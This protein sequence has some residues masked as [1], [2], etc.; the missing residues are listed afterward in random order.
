MVGDRHRAVADARGEHLGQ[1]RRNR[2]VGQRRQHAQ[3]Q[4]QRNDADDARQ[5]RDLPFERIA[6]A[7]EPALDD[8]AAG[9]GR[10]PFVAVALCADGQ[11]RLRL[12]G[13]RIGYAQ[14]GQVLQ[15]AAAGAGLHFGEGI[16]F[17]GRAADRDG[18]RARAVL[19]ARVGERADPPEHGEEQRQRGQRADDDRF[20]APDAVGPFADDDIEAHRQRTRDQQHPFDHVLVDPHRAAQE[21]QAGEESGV[22]DR[23]EHPGDAEQR[24]ED[25]LGVAGIGQAFLERIGAGFAC[26]LHRLEDGAFRQLE[27]HPQRDEQQHDRQQERDPPAPFGEVLCGDERAAGDYH[28]DRQ[29]EA[30]DHA[31]LDEAGVEAAFLGRRV[32]GDIDRRAAIFAAERETL[33]D[34]QAD[35]DQRRGDADAGRAGDEAH[36][37]GGDAHQRDRHE[38]G[39]FAPQPVAEEAE[40]DRAQRTEAEADR[41]T[42]PHQQDLERLVIAREEGRTDQPCKRAVDEEIVPFEDRP[43]AACRNDEAY[44]LL[45]RFPLRCDGTCGHVALPLHRECGCRSIG[46]A[47]TPTLGKRV[48]RGLPRQENGPVAGAV[49]ARGFE[50]VDPFERGR[51]RI[52]LEP[53]AEGSQRA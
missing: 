4:Q 31:G 25:A 41:E 5:W 12:L 48:E 6:I 28:Q 47:C 10:Q 32:F 15:R 11:F 46:L 50:H 24:H 26:G 27:P 21:G 9:V 19:Q 3:H 42:G 29:H 35:H 2:T 23:G 45:G 37:G 22:P 14:R 52:A 34:A 30:A 39:V 8:R 49:G 18:G 17:A 20:L 13:H 7:L 16:V 51:V 44:F 38:E 43:R 40:Q 36:A 33:E 53:F 1:E